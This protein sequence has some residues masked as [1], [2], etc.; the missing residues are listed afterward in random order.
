[1]HKKDGLSRMAVS[2]ELFNLAESTVSGLGYELVDV[3]R[4]PRGL[5]RVTIDS[6]NGITLEDCEAVSNV[7]NPALTVENV[8]FDRLEISS[9]GLDR[10][11]RR[12][13]D[14]VRFAGEVVHVELYAP[15]QAEG[16][17]ENGRR[18]FDI[19]ILGVSGEETDPVIDAEFVPEVEK[20]TGKLRFR[21]PKKPA[22]EAAAIVLAIPFKDI[23]K[24]NLKMELDF[25]GKK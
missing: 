15:M 25:R 3:E 6:E 9:P 24:A 13:K 4:L 17:P 8:D 22:V 11:L 12:V 14:F 5:I 23:E 7:L 2:A 16:F 19:R 21:A 1:M 18:R 10:P 20:P